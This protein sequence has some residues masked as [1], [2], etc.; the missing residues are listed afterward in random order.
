MI[1]CGDG[2]HEKTLEQVEN[3]VVS[4][5]DSALILL[6]SINDPY[7]LKGKQ[8]ARHVI[9]SLYAKDLNGQ[10]ILPDTVIFQTKFHLEKIN[11]SKYLALVEYYI[12]RIYQ[13]Q[14][15]GKQAIQYYLSARKNAE[16]SGDD[17]IKGLILSY[18]GYFYSFNEKKSEEAVNCLKSALEC[19]GKSPDNYRRK[20]S[21][22]NILGNVFLF[23]DNKDSAV[24]CYN[25]AFKLAQTAKDSASIMQNLSTVYLRNNE[26]DKAKQH[27]FRAL[28]LF[29]D[30]VMQNI[31]YLNLSKIYEQKN[32]IDSAFYFAQL[33]ENF[34]TKKCNIHTVTTIYKTLS[35][36]EKKKGHYDKALYYNEKYLEYY[37][38]IKEET[39]FDIQQIEA[40]HNLSILQSKQAN[41]RKIIRFLA[42]ISVT[43][44]GLSLCLIRYG[45]QKKSKC[46]K[47]N[48]ELVEM[49]NT[50]KKLLL[51]QTETKTALTE[52]E[53]ALQESQ[54]ELVNKTNVLKKI[55][56]IF[57]KNVELSNYYDGIKE[58]S[59][60]M[61][62]LS[63]DPVLLKMLNNNDELITHIISHLK[64]IFCKPWKSI[65]TKEQAVFD[66]IKK[67]YPQLNDTEHQI[68]CLDYLGYTNA[69]IAKI[70][71]MS[72]NT[73]EQT[74]VNIRKK[75]NLKAKTNIAV[76]VRE[77]VMKS[78]FSN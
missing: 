11:N 63:S 61:E 38:K 24:I 15:D 41:Y 9:L 57:G 42:I 68:T 33:S 32:L 48:I 52:K 21:V 60:N 20:M 64:S 46:K 5:P 3:I 55:Q 49:D 59:I 67:L 19:F 23:K 77:Q 37:K 78:V 47:I 45:F 10:D 54:Y 72:I 26:I 76:H 56:S 74:K 50:L 75:L 6:E 13:A 7:K 17:N 25:E 66:E 28:N 27:L 22:L 1:S 2:N 31:I 30:S 69:M 8:F 12:G 34:L 51:E 29:S 39:E 18:I 58:I 71:D 65:Y 14:G 16:L 43:V 73:V 4:N 53:N 70:S 40:K 35:R 36:L 44:T 62:K